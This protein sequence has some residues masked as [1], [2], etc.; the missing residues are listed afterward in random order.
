MA[1]RAAWH[2][3]GDG[4][5]FN[6]ECTSK[7]S[8]QPRT[9]LTSF[10]HAGA[11]SFYQELSPNAVACPWLC[12]TRDT[13]HSAIENTFKQKCQI[14]IF[15]NSVPLR[16]QS[17]R[18]TTALGDDFWQNDRPRLCKN[19]VS[20]VRS[21]SATVSRLIEYVIRTRSNYN[22]SP[23]HQNNSRR[24]TESNM[25]PQSSGRALR[26]SAHPR[27]PNRSAIEA[28]RVRCSNQIELC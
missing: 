3:L 4:A 2:D 7:N 10:S 16:Q 19:E 27:I 5:C 21:W 1:M 28:N 9:K 12:S 25:V 24:S 20:F 8:K 6:I 13:K 17:Q 22:Q 15:S 26:L 11:R 23:S 14:E 18:Y